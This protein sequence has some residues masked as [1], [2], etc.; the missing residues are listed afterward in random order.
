MSIREQII[1]VLN[2]PHLTEPDKNN[3][4]RSIVEANLFEETSETQEDNSKEQIFFPNSQQNVHIELNN[5][6][7]V[8]QVHGKAIKLPEKVNA[9]KPWENIKVWLWSLFTK[10]KRK[11]ITLPLFV[12]FVVIILFPEY[13]EKFSKGIEVI[14]NTFNHK[15][16]LSKDEYDV[17]NEWVSEIWCFDD[18]TKAKEGYAN[19]VNTY[20]NSK[21]STWINDIFLVRN[22]KE[23]KNWCIVIDMDYGNSS[24][25]KTQNRINKLKEYSNSTRDLQNTLGNWLQNYNVKLYDKTVFEKTYGQIKNYKKKDFE[26]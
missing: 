23:E 18:H 10:G 16:S 13:K 12:M 7:I 6:H 20:K 11:Y 15:E 26:Q 2:N 8:L 14:H 5:S 19:F 21:H 3:S 9:D 24:K 4:I 22:Y 1:S 25:E 17:M